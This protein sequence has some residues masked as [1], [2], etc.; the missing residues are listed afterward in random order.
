M[1][2]NIDGIQIHPLNTDK[3]LPILTSP[4]DKNIPTTGTKI[5]NY[6]YIQNNFS[7]IPCMGNK[8]KAPPQK[9]DADKQ[10]QFDENRQNDGPDRI[11]GV[12]SVS[13]PGN[14]K[15]ATGDL[16]IKLEG[17]AHQIKCKPTQR[18]NS[19]AEK[20]F[21]G[22]PAGLC[23]EG[24]MCSI[25]HGLKNCEKTLC[26]AKKFS[27]KANMDRYQLPLPV[28]NGY[29]KQVTPPKTISNLE[30]GDYLLN[31]LAEL[32]K[33]GCKIFVIEYDPIDNQC[34]AP[35]WDLFINSGDMA[36]ILGIRVK[37]QVIPSLGECNPNFITKQC[38]YCK[39][40]VNYSSKV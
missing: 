1:H 11:M 19:K 37:V 25:R 34:M 26:N 33:N 24:I 35:V 30:S 17:D 8:P 23:S 12:M 38:W 9:V 18:K 40:H 22:I 32:N 16:L 3:S 20:M 28:M 29:F 7:L 15:Q 13:T 36:D 2:A 21:P 14:V 31:K 27:T 10:F 39:H 4:K 5:R 6:S